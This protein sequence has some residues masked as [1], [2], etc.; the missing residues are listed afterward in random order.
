MSLFPRIVWALFRQN[1][2]YFNLSF[3]FALDFQLEYLLFLIIVHKN[4][5]DKELIV[6][7]GDNLHP[8]NRGKVLC[9]ENRSVHCLTHLNLYFFIRSVCIH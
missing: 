7:K 6:I 5:N 8:H 1:C 4:Q 3:L 2:V 9:H